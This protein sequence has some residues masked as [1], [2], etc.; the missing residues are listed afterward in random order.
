MSFTNNLAWRYATKKFS[1]KKVDD[2]TLAKIKEAIHM[3]PSSYGLQPY[4]VI[5]VTNP[6]LRAKLREKSWNQTQITDASHL[7]VFCAETKI[8]ERINSLLEIISGGNSEIRKGMAGYE[9]MMTGFAGNLTGDKRAAWSSKQTYIALGFA[10]AA[11]AELQVDSCPMEGFDSEGYREIL[12]IP[13]NLTAVVV[14]T[15]GYRSAEDDSSPDK[16]P[17]ARF[18]EEVLFSNK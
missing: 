5:D 15:V 6:E 8:E 17:K 12:S 18:S 2:T 16:R 13:E 9:G 4:H 11:C 14:L 10:L 3:A 7:F 1:D